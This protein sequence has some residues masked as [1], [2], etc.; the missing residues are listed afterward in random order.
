M[1]SGKNDGKSN[2]IL[3]QYNSAYRGCRRQGTALCLL[4]QRNKSCRTENR[5]LSCV[6]YVAVALEGIEKDEVVKQGN[7]ETGVTQDSRSS[8]IRIADLFAKINLKDGSFR[9]GDGSLS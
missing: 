1:S 8:I 5:P 4:V 2:V 6:L 9:T 3:W 7:T